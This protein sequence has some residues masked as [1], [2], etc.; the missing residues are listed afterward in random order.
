MADFIDR[1]ADVGSESDDEDFDDEGE[2]TSRKPKMNGKSGDNDDSSEEEDDDD[3]EA[4][5]EVCSCY[6]TLPGFRS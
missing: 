6:A 1:I 2:P 4:A 3:E 5:R